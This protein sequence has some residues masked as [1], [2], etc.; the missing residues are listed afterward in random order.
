MQRN[1]SAGVW[2]AFPIFQYTE[3]ANIN[4]VPI[5]VCHQGCVVHHPGQVYWGVQEWVK[6][7]H[8]FMM[9][10]GILCKPEC[11]TGL[12][13]TWCTMTVVKESLI[14]YTF[15]LPGT[16]PKRNSNCK[17]LLPELSES[18]FNFSLELT[19]SNN[20]SEYHVHGQ[21]LSTLALSLSVRELS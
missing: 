11:Y 8:L 1:H 15:R 21:L 10:S 14:Y 9:G 16:L 17:V 7:L 20:V 13:H 4:G 19:E 2:N 6:C 18:V 5:C 12:M 3:R